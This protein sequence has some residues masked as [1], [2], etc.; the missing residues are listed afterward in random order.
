LVSNKKFS[1]DLVD[2][3]ANK[4]I[5][6]SLVAFPTETVYGLGAD[7][8]NELAVEKI[9]KTKGRPTNHP[10]IAHIASPNSLNIWAKNVNQYALQLSKNFWPGPMTLVFERTSMAKDWITGGQN[11]VALRVPN[12]P[13]ALS[14]LRQFESLGGQGIAAPSANRF[15]AVSPT[16]SQAVYEELG[17]YLDKNK[18]L[19]LD[20]GICQVGLESTII[21][22]T[23]KKPRILRLGA[24]TGA[25][26]EE[27]IGFPLGE[28]NKSSI[29]F[30]GSLDSHYAPTAKIYL[31]TNSNPEPGDGL[32]AI[33]MIPTPPGV[34]RL[35]APNS[36][37]VYAREL[38]S[39]LRLG[40][41]MKIR[42]IHIIQPEG[43]GLAEAIRDRIKR[44]AF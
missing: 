17:L 26:I 35:S 30:P 31:G 27:C 16:S 1:Q 34:I 19:I 39:A 6:G 29:K 32:I 33:K 22:C 38:Y 15:G 8:S 21:D 13:I 37:E 24:I 2:L 3:A 5:E 14:L 10:L 41:S 12:H 40:D 18:D 9:Y 36:L 4:L 44:A 20:G 25:M 11:T 42:K 43:D 7:A 23:Q 28:I